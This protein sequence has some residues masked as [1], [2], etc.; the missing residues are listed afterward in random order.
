MYDLSPAQRCY[1][2]KIFSGI[3][4]VRKSITHMMCW[5]GQA[6]GRSF[7]TGHDLFRFEEEGWLYFE[8]ICKENGMHS[9]GP[10]KTSSTHLQLRS[11]A[12][13][14]CIKKHGSLYIIRFETSSQFSVFD[15]I[16]GLYSRYGSAQ[17]R[18]LIGTTQQFQMDS[19]MHEMGNGLSSEPPS[20]KR[21]NITDFGIDLRYNYCTSIYSIIVRY[22]KINVAHSQKL[23]SFYQERMD[24]D[25]EPPPSTQQ[26]SSDTTDYSKTVKQGSYF[27]L[28]NCTYKVLE[29]YS[30]SKSSNQ[31][32]VIS[33]IIGSDQTVGTREQ[34]DYIIINR[35]VINLIIQC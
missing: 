25:G 35:E 23:R 26:F 5:T 10:F 19:Q 20:F 4:A 18:P 7:I 8:H 30:V 16:F 33:T 6:N 1:G 28:N 32:K 22:Q 2:R 24:Y 27:N 29:N 34:F 15:N 17:K 31:R 9:Q 13:I 11:H 21:H 3:Y 12:D 14:N